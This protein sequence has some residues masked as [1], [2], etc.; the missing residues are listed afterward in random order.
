MLCYVMLCYVMLYAGLPY[1]QVSAM[2]VRMSCLT[3]YCSKQQASFKYSYVLTD[4]CFV[5]WYVVLLVLCGKECQTQSTTWLSLMSVCGF[6]VAVSLLAMNVLLQFV[7][8]E[9]AHSIQW[10]GFGLY[11]LWFNFQQGQKIFFFSETSGLLLEPTDPHT[12][13]VQWPG[14]AAD[15]WPESGARLRMSATMCFFCH[16]EGQLCTVAFHL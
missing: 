16:A 3:L 6:S 8:V 4:S 7:R 11:E 2:F 9:V 12:K 14:L 15:H 10:L 13:C 1:I 5:M